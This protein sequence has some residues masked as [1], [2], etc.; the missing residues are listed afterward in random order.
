MEQLLMDFAKS[1]V[2]ST[3]SSE[4]RHAR[5]S[6]S[7]ARG[8][9]LSKVN[10]Q[11]LRLATYDWLARH[12]QGGLSGR[13]FRGFSL[14]EAG[15]TSRP[16]SDN[17]QDGKCP[18]Q[19]MGGATEESY[20][21][22]AGD[23]GWPTECLTLNIREFPDF[24]AQSRSADGAFS[25]SDTV[26][27]LTEVLWT[28]SIPLRYYLTEKACR[29]I[30]RRAENRGK[31]LP[32]ILRKALTEQAVMMESLEKAMKSQRTEDR[33]AAGERLEAEARRMG[34][35]DAYEMTRQELARKARQRESTRF[36]PT[37][38]TP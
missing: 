24:Q 2:E 33:L 31:T 37:G 5:T 38:A 26:A 19:P 36:A 11:V 28:G 17:S 23:T 21:T 6:A 8:R 10:A 13:M 4:E 7:R 3:S 18:C 1:K 14:P 15:G 12:V 35:A 29:G 16:S 25:S 22:S 32:Y 27:G 20:R 9:G 34:F 30:L